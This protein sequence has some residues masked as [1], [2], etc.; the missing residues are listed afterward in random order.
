MPLKNSQASR[1]RLKPQMTGYT[2][3]QP[4]AYLLNTDATCP[5]SIRK[6]YKTYSEELCQ[7][8]QQKSFVIPH[9]RNSLEH[10]LTT[11]TS[12]YPGV[13]GYLKLRADYTSS[14][15]DSGGKRGNQPP[16]LNKKAIG[17]WASKR[18]IH[19]TPSE[20]VKKR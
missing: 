20:H 7:P 5:L 17:S 10:I 16:R 18:Q 15:T 13:L 19:D 11:P 6:W 9:R 12:K 4:P 2:H 14:N 3:I 1:C 8:S